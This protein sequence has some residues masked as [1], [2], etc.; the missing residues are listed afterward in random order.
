MHFHG[1]IYLGIAGDAMHDN[2]PAV[3]DLCRDRFTKYPNLGIWAPDVDWTPHSTDAARCRTLGRP[4]TC[5][6]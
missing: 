6:W 4:Q 3:V 1:D 2:W 5:S